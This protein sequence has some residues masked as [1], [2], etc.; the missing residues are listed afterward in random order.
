MR[1]DIHCL[2]SCGGNNMKRYPSIFNDALAPVTP[3]PSSSNTCGPS[4]IAR[5]CRQL[6]GEKPQRVIVEIS[7]KG[8]LIVSYLGMHTDMAFLNG[9]LG[10]ACTDER[11]THA[12]E[13]ASAEGIELES[14]YREELPGIPTHLAVLTFVGKAGKRMKFRTVSTGGGAFLIDEIDGCPVH[15]EGDCEE[16]LVFTEPLSKQQIEEMVGQTKRFPGFNCAQWRG[17][18]SFG[19]LQIKTDRPVNGADLTA[20]SKLPFVRTFRQAHPELE[21]ISSAERKPPFETTAQMIAYV[22]ERKLPLW[23]AA[24]HYEAAISGW[25]EEKVVQTVRSRWEVIERSV[26]GGLR[27]GNNMNGIVAA[28]APRVKE[29]FQ[30]GSLIPLGAID[31]GAPFSLAIMEY[32]NC[33]G[34]IT[35]IPTG[36][37]SGVVPGALYGAAVSMKK[38]H[39]ELLHALL[40]AGLIGT[41]MEPTK[42]LGALGCQA[43][44]GCAAGMASAG[45]ISL[46]GGTAEQA[47]EAAVMSIQSLTG[48]LCDKI[49]G[50]VQ[51]PCLSRNMTAVSI[52]ATCANAVMAGMKPLVPLEETV[53]SMLQSGDAIRRY[54]INRMGANGTTTGLRLTEEQKKRRERLQSD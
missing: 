14:R 31:Y 34:V 41:F 15:I 49:G 47:C 39:E 23:K 17:G 38:T 19:I 3:G 27:E 52:A 30:D 6:F 11:F 8:N 54:G 1:P 26:Q 10:R 51:V 28:C 40:V 5:T 25:T 36:G 29:K 42:Y 13:D 24:V 20:F 2:E 35:C 16:L 9:A 12:F 32:S 21:V 48:L 4:R 33:S 18:D 43:E 45:L 7:T 50:L 46:L 53:Q 44:I 37:S 22:N